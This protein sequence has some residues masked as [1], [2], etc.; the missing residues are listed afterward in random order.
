[1]TEDIF[2]LVKSKNRLEDVI[3]EDGHKLEGRGRYR[4]IPHS[5]GF[6]I[7]THTQTWHHNLEIDRWGDVIAWVQMEHKLD[8]KEA[9]NYLAKRAGL[10]EPEWKRSNSVHAVATRQK[11][12]ALKIAAQVFAG[13]F[14][15]SKEAK[16]YA[17]SRGWTIEIPGEDGKKAVGGTARAAMLGYSGHGSDAEKEEMRQAFINAEVDLLSPAAVAVLGFRGDV[18]K[19]VAQHLPDKTVNDLPEDWGLKGYIP[20]MLGRD[21]LVYVHRISGRVVYLSGRGISEKFHWNL[22]EA[23]VG[24]RQPYFNHEYSPS[25]ETC[26]IVEGQADAI[27]LGQLGI[28]AVAL[29]GTKPKDGLSA[30]LRERHKSIVVWADLD[31]AGVLNAWRNADDIGPMTRITCGEDLIDFQIKMDEN[32]SDLKKKSVDDANAVLFSL[33]RVFNFPIN[34]KILDREKFIKDANDLLIGLSESKL[35][36]SEQKK[37]AAGLLLAAPTFAELVAAWAGT[38]QGAARDHAVRVAL[39]VFTRMGEMDYNTYRAGLGKML[40]FGVR[41]LGNM[42]KTFK[43]ESAKENAVGE[44]EFTLGG[45]IK[46]YVVDYLYDREKDQALLAWRDPSGIIGYGPS[47]TIEGKRYEPI[48]P[49][50]SMKTGGILFPSKL[51]EKKSIADL[52]GYIELYLGAVYLM[53][54]KTTSRLLAYYVLSTWVYD[55]FDALAYLAFMGDTGS[56]KSELMFRVGMICYRP[57]TASGAST[58]ASLF[59]MVHRYKGCVIIDE[60]DL[61]QSDTT[62]DMVKFYNQGAM[63]GRPITRLG[64]VILPDGT[65]DYE[66]R[67]FDVYCP[68]LMTIK[69]SFQD[70]AV[71]SR[72]LVIK[73]QPREML[74]LVNAKIPLSINRN[75]REKTQALRNLLIR[76]RLEYWQQQIEMDDSFY[77]MSVSAR[78]NQI[79]GGLLAIAKDDPT[80][81]EQ[82][83][84]NLREYYR[85]SQVTK[86][87]SITAR[88]IEALWQM[89]KFPDL[90]QQYV[91]QE[92]DGRF[93]IKIGDITKTANEIIDRMNETEEELD[94]EDDKKYRK[95]GIKPHTVGRIVRDELQL[96]VS[97]RRRDGFW[98]YWNEDRMTGVALRF[99]ID[100]DQVGPMITENKNG[101]D[102]KA[103]KQEKLV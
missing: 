82:I 13:W 19:W 33:S 36:E 81:Q 9:V 16:A 30:D 70:D 38:R 20:G 96:E 72:S 48:Q 62:Q 51:G 26:V 100:L 67:A 57:I 89:W 99:G 32:D 78:L 79:T 69:K 39:G 41:E 94:N 60:A 18:S 58:V 8:N 43:E 97:R 31:A 56:G 53:P 3:A 47:V 27:S 68:K 11:Q 55:C 45:F 10:P 37:S 63:K 84:D 23:L 75:I 4:K 71:T 73:L 77:E 64:D 50:E 44:P 22:P 101:S 87:M 80:Q 5:G 88:V 49:T 95:K 46:G 86:S 66:E 74:E 21:R 14:W 17:V 92:D 91:R 40:G 76:F 98:V 85:D 1:M 59:R 25:A 24:G 65:H 2:A 102:P 15:K 35:N 34:S 90:N 83:R 93:A 42:L 6:V 29:C 103:P 7:D 12:D 61:Q 28:A 52:V 54:N